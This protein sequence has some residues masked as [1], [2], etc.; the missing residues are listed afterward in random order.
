L[1]LA[2]QAVS[3]RPL[4]ERSN[5]HLAAGENFPQ[6]ALCQRGPPFA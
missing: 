4:F 1:A 3:A 2:Q 6:K 5:G